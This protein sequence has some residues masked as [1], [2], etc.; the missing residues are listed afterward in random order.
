VSGLVLATAGCG[1]DESTG[2]PRIASIVITSPIGDRLAVG[3]TVQLVP[4]ARDARGNVIA[5]VPF[6]WSSTATG[7]A[8]VGT[9]GVVSGASVGSATISA[10][11]DGVTGTIALQVKAADLAGITAAMS[12]P[13]FLALVTALTTDVR[14]RTQT[15]LAE[16]SAGVT[17]GNFSRVEACLAGSRTEVSSATN[18]SDRAILAT[19]AL[20]L[21]H[22]DRLLHL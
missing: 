22:I 8:A 16:C 19:L 11:A 18:A 13:F 10:M 7:V 2:P 6:T 4:Q 3:R 9:S 20:F 17:A 14:G 12:D 5:N 15:A 21:D 1:G